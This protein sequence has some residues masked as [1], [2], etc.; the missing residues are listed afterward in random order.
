MEKCHTWQPSIESDTNEAVSANECDGLTGAEEFRQTRPVQFLF[1]SEQ[2]AGAK[3]KARR[4]NKEVTQNALMNV[5]R[6]APAPAF[7]GIESNLY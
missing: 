1:R 6:K 5:I 2:K 4:P 7:V 3:M